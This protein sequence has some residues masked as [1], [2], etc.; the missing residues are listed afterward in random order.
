[1]TAAHLQPL[2]SAGASAV[3]PEYYDCKCMHGGDHFRLLKLHAEEAGKRRD[4]DLASGA[5]KPEVPTHA[6]V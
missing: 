4:F 1:M 3:I 6:A 2:S 5:R